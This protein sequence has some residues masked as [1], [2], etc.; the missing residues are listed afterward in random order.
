[1]EPRNLMQQIELGYYYFRKICK[2]KSIKVKE[3]SIDVS[4]VNVKL[5]IDSK[6]NR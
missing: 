6:I 4:N 1:M 3:M 2:E 5:A